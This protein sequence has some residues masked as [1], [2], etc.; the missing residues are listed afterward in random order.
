MLPEL[1]ASGLRRLPGCITEEHAGTCPG[2]RMICDLH[3]VS[4]PSPIQ[5]STSITEGGGNQGMYVV[6]KSTQLV[7]RG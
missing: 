5:D 1:K 4:G 6:Y 7:S 2:S 3:E